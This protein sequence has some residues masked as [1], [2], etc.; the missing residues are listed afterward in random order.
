MI[1]A[2]LHGKLSREQENMEDVL[3]S[4]VFGLL[5]YV[6]PNEG[7]LP[8]LAQAETPDGRKPLGGLVHVTDIA[9]E[10]VAYLFWP[11][12]REKWP[13]CEPD[14][15][16]R[17]S[18]P[19]RRPAI[20]SVEAKYHSGKS[21]FP[22]YTTERLTDQLAREWDD[23][24]RRSDEEGAE[25]CLIFL[26]TDIG[27]PRSAIEESLE[28]YRRKRIEDD[29]TPTIC[30]LSWRRLEALF[31]GVKNPMLGQLGELAQRLGLTYFR[32]IKPF[33]C[34]PF[35]WS[36]DGFDVEFAFDCQPAPSQWKF[37]R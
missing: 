11:T 4:N 30:W 9:C 6:Q 13:S 5:R 10:E 21:S 31:S 17:V 35:E 15:V 1:E 36:F 20:I 34:W 33:A 22:D 2:L 18:F 19:H 32:G 37:D 28:E 29:R 23:L 24:V 8:F 14:V 26:T 27:C 16:I 12:N 3:T 25:P 7:L